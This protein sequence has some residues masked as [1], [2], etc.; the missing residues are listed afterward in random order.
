MEYCF[1]VFNGGMDYTCIYVPVM[2]SI[3][4]NVQRTVDVKD[5]M[6]DYH[7]IKWWKVSNVINHE[8]YLIG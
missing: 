2:E 1:K 3:Q 5:S 6:N 7:T 4:W 8:M